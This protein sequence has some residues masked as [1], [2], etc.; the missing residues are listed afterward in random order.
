MLIVGRRRRPRPPGRERVEE[1]ERRIAG[2]PGVASVTGFAETRSR[3]FVSRDGDSTYLAVG[4]ESTD[5]DETQDVAERIADSLEDEPG[6][7]RR[8]LGGRPGAGQRAGRDRPAHRPSCS[9]SRSSSCSRC[10]SSAASSPRCCRC[11]SAGW[12][13]SARFLTLRVASEMGS[14]SIFALNLVT[15]LGLGLAIDYSLFIVSRYREEIARSGP[16]L[17]G[18]AADDGDRRADVL[19]SSLTVAGALAS[20]LVFPQRFLY[21]MG[22]GGSLVALIAAAIALVVLPA[23]L[24]LLGERVNSLSPAFLHRRAERDARPAS[25]GF[26]YRLSPAG[27]AVPGPDRRGERG[28]ADRARDPVLLRSSSPPSTPRCCPSRPAPARSTTRCAPTSRPS[29]TRRSRSRSTGSTSARP[30]G[31]LPRPSGSTGVAAV[32]PPRRLEGVG[33]RDRGG[34]EH[35]AAQRREPGSGRAPARARPC[36]S[37]DRL[38]RPL[39]RPAGEP[40]RPPAAGAGDRRRGHLRRPLPD[41]RLGDPAAEADA[42]ERARAQRHLRDPGADL[43]GRAL[44]GPARLHE[45][46]RARVDPAAAAVR[47]RLRALDRLRRLPAV[48]DQGGARRGPRR[49]ATRSRS[50]SSAPAGS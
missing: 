5:D 1:V 19:F 24:A 44:R 18:D 28:V 35:R 16:G 32:N 7:T 13:S 39:P 6:V 45:P 48:A 43:P 38:H 50:G 11:W 8:R 29:T 17:G 10:S 23:V 2:D 31:S 22:I 4:L 15:G 49:L 30:S 25:E 12:R 34:L 21:S 37:R 41:D 9:P 40:R 27:D 20:L 14:I 3:A 33:L 36:A 42:D 46:G 26:W 47:G